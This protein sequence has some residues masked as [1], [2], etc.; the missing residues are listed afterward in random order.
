[1]KAIGYV[2]CSTQEQSDSGLGLEAQR[3]RIRAYAMLKGLRLVD[4][5]EDAAVSGGKLLA[6]RD[7]GRRL[8][9]VLRQR[10]VDSVVIP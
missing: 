2:R 5:I 3:K 7:G 6:S 1:M 9:E 8:L 4:I 10:R